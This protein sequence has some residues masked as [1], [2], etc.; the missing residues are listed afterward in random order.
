M[1]AKQSPC[2]LAAHDISVWH[3]CRGQVYSSGDSYELNASSVTITGGEFTD[4]AAFELGGALVA[5]GPPNVLNVW[6]GLFANN[7][8]R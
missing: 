1:H 2:L 3:V 7:T 5:W 8:A 4:N 6:G